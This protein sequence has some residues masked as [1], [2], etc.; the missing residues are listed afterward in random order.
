MNNQEDLRKELQSLSPFLELLKTEKEG[1]KTPENYFDTLADE[2]FWKMR[3]EPELTTVI[4]PRKY[5]RTQLEEGLKIF[6]QPRWALALASVLLILGT[7]IFFIRPFFQ[8]RDA[9]AQL[10]QD[11]IHQYLMNHAQEL[12]R[13]TLVEITEQ[14]HAN[15]QIDPLLL[16]E[17][18]IDQYLDEISNDL[19]PETLEKIF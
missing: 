1:F 4:P 3:T 14:H 17:G 12:D 18:N 9:F 10:S 11:E 6:L 8:P 19:D 2:V 16:P 5:W 13:E 7:S 15:A